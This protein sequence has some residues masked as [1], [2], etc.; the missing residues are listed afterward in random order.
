[1]K[2]IIQFDLFKV[3]EKSLYIDPTNLYIN[4]RFNQV[5]LDDFLTNEE[6]YLSFL[7]A[8]LEVGGVKTMTL[9]IWEDSD[10]YKTWLDWREIKE[11]E[12]DF[13]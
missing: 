5:L 8:D 13:I 11:E 3:G 1:M 10:D 12:I 2:T 4:G 6:D 9:E 7:G